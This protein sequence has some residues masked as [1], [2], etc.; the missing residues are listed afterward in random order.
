MDI[1]HQKITIENENGWHTLLAY[2]PPG[3]K[4]KMRETGAFTRAREIKTPEDLLRIIFAP[5]VLQ[6]SLPD[7]SRWAAEMDL[8]HLAFPSLW[9]RLQKCVSFLRWLIGMLLIDNMEPPSGGLILAPIDATCFTLPSS[10]KREWMLHLVWANGMPIRALLR[11]AAGK[12]TGESLRNLDNLPSEAV[13]IGDRAYGTP[14]QLAHAFENNQ[15]FIVRFTWNNLPLFADKEQKIPLD[16]ESLMGDM[17]PGE[18]REWTAFV[19]PKGKKPFP[20]RVVAVRKTPEIAARSAHRSRTDSTR[21][22]HTPRKI[23]LFLSHFVT[24][25]TNVPFEQADTLAIAD[26]YRWRWQ[27]EREFRRFKSTTHVRRLPN[28]KD[29]SVEVYLLAL[30]AAW[31]LAHHI[32]RQSSF[33]PWGVP[34]HRPHR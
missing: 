23:T 32:A 6:L 28:H 19:R 31:L 21:K 5:P 3:W 17:R 10:K 20:I 22:G 27:I 2:L 9:E 18:T 11:K 1:L 34:L 13:R 24:L 26:S 15:K 7:L 4:E 25:A 16:P 33:S 12:G 29:D 14:P 30:L 8:A